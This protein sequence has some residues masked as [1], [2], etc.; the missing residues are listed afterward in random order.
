MRQTFALAVQELLDSLWELSVDAFNIALAIDPL[1]ALFAIVPERCLHN[2]EVVVLGCWVL[3]LKITDPRDRGLPKECVTQGNQTSDPL[4]AK[5]MAPQWHQKSLGSCRCHVTCGQVMALV[6]AT[7]QLK[8]L[9]RLRC[10]RNRVEPGGNRADLVV[11]L[12]QNL[13]F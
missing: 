9:G 12:K 2:V 6:E 5:H 10:G 7:K 4:C 11:P 13:H 1:H 3:P 8:L